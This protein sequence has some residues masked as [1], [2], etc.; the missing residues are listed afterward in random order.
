MKP[1]TCPFCNPFN[2]DDFPEL[3]P[4]GRS[5]PKV[6]KCSMGK[7]CRGLKGPDARPEEFNYFDKDGKPIPYT[8][9]KGKVPGYSPQPARDPK[10]IVKDP[11][12]NDPANAPNLRACLKGFYKKLESKQEDI[13]PE[14][15]ELIDKHFWK[16]NENLLRLRTI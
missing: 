2:I 3:I 8:P 10:K 4:S 6:L 15:A 14:F 11:W 1:K 9:P 7:S 12:G 5:E 16:L 13:H